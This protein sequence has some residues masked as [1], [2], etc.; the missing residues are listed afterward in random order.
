[1]LS[2]RSKY[3]EPDY[4]DSGSSETH[5]RH[6]YKRFTIPGSKID[7]TFWYYRST[8]MM[9]DYCIL[10][11]KILKEDGSIQKVYLSMPAK[12]LKSLYGEPSEVV[13]FEWRYEH[14]RRA[15]YETC[16]IVVSNEDKVIGVPSSYISCLDYY[17]DETVMDKVID[18]GDL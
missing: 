16:S 14:L 8:I 1:M 11:S 6:Y 3:G 7:C 9:A 4:T 10:N 5:I 15:D 18:L 12:D 13:G 2:V 17:V